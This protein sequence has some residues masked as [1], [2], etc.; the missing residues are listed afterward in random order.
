M[1]ESSGLFIVKVGGVK[2][3]FCAENHQ[4]QNKGSFNSSKSCTVRKLEKIHPDIPARIGKVKSKE[5]DWGP[6][7]SL[8]TD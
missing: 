1:Q 6:C 7:E 4:L 3:G 5:I 2:I 8:K